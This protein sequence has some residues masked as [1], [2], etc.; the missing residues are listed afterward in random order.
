MELAV[1]AKSIS[2]TVYEVKPV[3][4]YVVPKAPE[5]WLVKSKELYDTQDVPFHLQT[6]PFSV[7]KVPNVGEPGKFNLA[8]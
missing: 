3:P 8:I 4:P 1:D 6:L 5:T 7:Y 2:P